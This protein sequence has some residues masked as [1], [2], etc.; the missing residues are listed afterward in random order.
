MSESL[1]SVGHQSLYSEQPSTHTQI[2]SKHALFSFVPFH[3]LFLR[4]SL[5]HG[6]HTRAS[7]AYGGAVRNLPHGIRA[8]G[9]ARTHSGTDSSPRGADRGGSARTHSGTD[10]DARVADR[11]GTRVFEFHFVL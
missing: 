6:I 1:F 7:A 8:T 2:H 9:S 3:S 4:Q 11:G 10:S 5:S